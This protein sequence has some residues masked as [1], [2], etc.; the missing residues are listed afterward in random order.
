M[1]KKVERIRFE[2]NGHHLLKDI[3]SWPKLLHSHLSKLGYNKQ[4][5]SR[6]LLCTSAQIHENMVIF[7]SVRKQTNEKTKQHK[8]MKNTPLP[9]KKVHTVAYCN[10]V[11]GIISFREIRSYLW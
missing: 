1:W 3:L 8:Q 2:K 4:N 7:L 10:T 9:P 6:G 11:T 5:K